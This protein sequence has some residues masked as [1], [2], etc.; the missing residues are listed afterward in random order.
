MN[1]G[2]QIISLIAKNNVITQSKL[3]MKNIISNTMSQI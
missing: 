2:H 3:E 1:N